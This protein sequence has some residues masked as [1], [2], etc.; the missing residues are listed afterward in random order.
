MKLSSTIPVALLLLATVGIALRLSPK[1]MPSLAAGSAPISEGQSLH[2]TLVPESIHD[3]DTFRVTDGSRE[4]EVSLCGVIAPEIEQP[5]GI[6][7]RDRLRQ[8]IARGNGQIILVP[9]ETDPD[10]R[11]VADAFIPLAYS[12]GEQKGKEIHL[13]SQM[14]LDG[15]AYPHPQYLSECPNA[16]VMQ[17]AQNEAESGSVGVWNSAVGQRP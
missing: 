10:G 9:V 8:M 15:M 14:L 1:L 2:V 16:A 3:G 5:I 7:A 6:E 4:T 17:T 11:I 13:N 12:V